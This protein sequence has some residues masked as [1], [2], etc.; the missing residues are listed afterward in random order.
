MKSADVTRYSALAVL[1]AARRDAGAAAGGKSAIAS[2]AGTVAA[3]PKRVSD[4]TV[5]KV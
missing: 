1:S 3:H 4:S 5:T 2:L